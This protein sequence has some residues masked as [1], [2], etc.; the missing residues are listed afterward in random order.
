MHR[1]IG[2]AGVALFGIGLAMACASPSTTPAVGARGAPLATR[3]LCESSQVTIFAEEL[4]ISAAERMSELVPEPGEGT[5]SLGVLLGDDGEVVSV[6]RV[7]APNAALAALAEEAVRSAGPY[8]PPHL[9][10]NCLVGQAIPIWF[11]Y[12]QVVDCQNDPEVGAYLDGVLREVLPRVTPLQQGW[13]Q[14]L[15]LRMRFDASGE[16]TALEFDE[17]LDPQ[18]HD[19]VA[20]AVRGAGPFGVVPPRLE[21]C[22]T[23]QS[24]VLF[25]MIA[26]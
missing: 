23:R 7:R 24:S 4:A 10:R 16:A 17:V 18:T 21:S 22:L 12:E 5:V 19:A 15:S 8:P 26:R 3:A 9:Y 2:R 20:E 1:S 6:S 11:R 25:L 13:T 14:N